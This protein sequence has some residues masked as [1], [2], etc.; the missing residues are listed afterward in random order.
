MKLVWK[1]SLV[2]VLL[3]AKYQDS[4]AQAVW[5]VRTQDTVAIMPELPMI[6]EYPAPP[7]YTKW[8]HELERCAKVT[9]PDTLL[10]QITFI[11]VNAND[12]KI[13]A[14]GTHTAPHLA[15]SVVNEGRTFISV[16]H[17]YNWR[18]VKHEL[19]HYALYYMFGDKYY[20]GPYGDH[21][22]EYFD[23]CGLYSAEERSLE[24]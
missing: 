3:S 12:F 1:F 18:T 24:R 22:P 17:M 5:G 23:K 2:I 14:D 8:L 13:N 7:V 20:G 10:S 9:F 11:E 19:L 6:A 15:V 4:G 16:A 21:P